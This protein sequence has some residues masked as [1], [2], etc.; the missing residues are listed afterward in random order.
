MS[1]A[2]YNN[3]RLKKEDDDLRSSMNHPSLFDSIVRFNRAFSFDDVPIIADFFSKEDTMFISKHLANYEIAAKLKFCEDAEIKIVNG[4]R[5]FAN[6]DDVNLL[7]I[8]RKTTPSLTLDINPETRAPRNENLQPLFMKW[9]L[10]KYDSFVLWAIQYLIDTGRMESKIDTSDDEK[11]ANSCEY[12]FA[13]NGEDTEVITYEYVIA[14]IIKYGTF[15]LFQAAMYCVQNCGNQKVIDFINKHW[16]VFMI[17]SCQYA[18]LNVFK[19]IDDEMF[20]YLDY[21]PHNYACYALWFMMKN[22]PSCS[23]D[24]LTYFASKS[25][26]PI[27]INVSIQF[28][29]D[30]DQQDSEMRKGVIKTAFKV[31]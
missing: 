26:K 18:N 8:E 14:Y 6:Y 24:M 12:V 27:N 20:Q 22:V 31:V 15:S 19:F 30:S 1:Q 16:T 3:L 11:R 7:E 10:K 5:V 21:E 13:N 4:K 9:I 25:S 17:F 28:S 29:F 23:S 2:I